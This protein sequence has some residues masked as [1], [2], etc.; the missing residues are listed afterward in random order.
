MDK[1]FKNDFYRFKKKEWSVKN[2]IYLFT[3]KTLW[4]ILFGRYAASCNNKLL[5]GILK[6]VSKLIGQSMGNEIDFSNI[7]P[8]LVLSHPY[9]ITVNPKVNMGDNVTLFK[10]CT[11]GSIRS[12]DKAGTP[13][14]G[15]EVVVCCNAMVCG[16]I[17]I[18]NNVLIAAGAYVNFNVPDNSV[19]IGN[20][21]I[22][23]YKDN[24]TI[25]YL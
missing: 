13:K 7:G 2:S 24:P 3:S 15:N 9:G 21:G 25:D 4:Y 23:Y 12:G 11:I 1:A 6:I 14:I 5:S 16:N 19:V 22:V 20:P 17:S 10:G 8:G 18:G